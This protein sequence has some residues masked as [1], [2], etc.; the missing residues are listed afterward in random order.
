MLCKPEF[1]SSKTTTTTPNPTGV[2]STVILPSV[3]IV[4]PTNTTALV[5]PNEKQQLVNAMDKATLIEAKKGTDEKC[6]L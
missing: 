2:T 4:P 6:F 3:A 1:I 5:S